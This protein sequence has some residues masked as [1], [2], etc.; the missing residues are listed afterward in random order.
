MSHFLFV[1][2]FQ[3]KTK[4]AAL[5][6]LPSFQRACLRMTYVSRIGFSCRRTVL[7]RSGL[8]VKSGWSRYAPLSTGVSIIAVQDSLHALSNGFRH[9]GSCSAP[10]SSVP[11]DLIFVAELPD[12]AANAYA[13]SP[14]AAVSTA[15]IAMAW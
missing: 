10:N 13:A 12:G 4:S 11:P 15:T 2:V 7:T 8:Y 1:A 9:D 3:V 14:S 6:G 5:T